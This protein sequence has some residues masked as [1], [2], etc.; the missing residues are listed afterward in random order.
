MH[1]F[2]PHANKRT[3]IFNET[4]ADPSRAA[5]QAGRPGL[6]LHDAPLISLCPD[7]VESFKAPKYF[8]T[9]FEELSS[10]AGIDAEKDY[11]SKFYPSIFAGSRGSRTMLHADA[12]MTRFWLFQLTGMLL[13]SAASPAPYV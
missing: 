3:E 7:A 11:R 6:Y 9:S 13:L 8:P 1:D 5:V 10:D 2:T 12:F 4:A